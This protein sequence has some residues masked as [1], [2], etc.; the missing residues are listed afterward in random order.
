MD[1]ETV[2][3]EPGINNFPGPPGVFSRHLHATVAGARPGL[4]GLS[5]GGFSH[6]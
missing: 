2:E 4:A 3:G 1:A 5:V 6:F